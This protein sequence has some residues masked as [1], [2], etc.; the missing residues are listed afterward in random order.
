LK[1]RL[2]IGFY[3]VAL[4][5]SVVFLP[6]ILKSVICILRYEIEQEIEKKTLEKFLFFQYPLKKSLKS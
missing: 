4:F 2:L 5:F 6:I 1:G 3:S